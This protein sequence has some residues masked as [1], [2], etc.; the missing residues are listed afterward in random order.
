MRSLILVHGAGSGPWVFDGW[1]AAFPGIEV[2]AVDLHAGLNL[3]EAAMSNYA[4]IVARAADWLPRPLALCGWSMGGLVA[5][6]AARQAGADR[7]VLLEPSP[8]GELQGFAGE[9]PLRPG[10]FGPEE[11]YGTFAQGMR[12]RPESLLARAERKRGVSVPTLP[13]PALVVSGDDFRDERGAAVAAFYGA[14][15]LQLAGFGHWDLVLAPRAR[16]EVARWL[17]AESGGLPH[18][19]SSGRPGGTAMTENLD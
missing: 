10:T 5:M 18:N 15:S 17:V 2:G 9:P 13:C 3:A 11:V 19:S 7:L 6:L 1:A 8:P 14:E 4:A 16:A 12:S